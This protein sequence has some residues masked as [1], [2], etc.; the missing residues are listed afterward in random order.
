MKTKNHRMHQMDIFT[1]DIILSPRHPFVLQFEVN[2]VQEKDGWYLDYIDFLN[3]KQHV[4]MG[5]EHDADICLWVMRNTVRYLDD[6]E[7]DLF[8]KHNDFWFKK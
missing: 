7:S 2:K 6:Y 4:F 1:K 3:E 8:D 5:S